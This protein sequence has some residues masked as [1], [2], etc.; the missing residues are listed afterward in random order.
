MLTKKCCIGVILTV[1]ISIFTTGCDS[2]SS[3]G[4]GGASMDQMAGAVD[5]QNAAQKQQ[6]DAAAQKAEQDRI[7]A[8]SAESEMSSSP[9]GPNAGGWESTSIESFLE[10]AIA[11]AEAS[12]FGAKQPAPPRNSWQKFAAFLYCGKIYE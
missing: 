9:Y 10:S 1:A 11:W 4:G 8:V 12:E 3:K 7:A 5:A 2:S 6:A